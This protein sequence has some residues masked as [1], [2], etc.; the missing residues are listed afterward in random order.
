MDFKLMLP[1][2]RKGFHVWTTNNFWQM[3]HCPFSITHWMNFISS[4]LQNKKSSLSS[5]HELESS[6]PISCWWLWLP[7]DDLGLHQP[8]KQF[9]HFLMPSTM[10]S[11]GNFTILSLDALTWAWKESLWLVSFLK[12][13][14]QEEIRVFHHILRWRQILV[15]CIV[16][17][18]LQLHY[19]SLKNRLTG[20]GKIWTVLEKW[21]NT[22]WVWTRSGKHFERTLSLSLT[23]PS[24]PLGHPSFST[25]II[26]SY[27]WIFFTIVSWISDNCVFS[28]S[29]FSAHLIW[30]VSG[31]FNKQVVYRLKYF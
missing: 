7:D 8:T 24:L 29:H 15:V 22:C 17:L 21:T 10:A 30:I 27:Q 16:R 25:I 13:L 23:N 19:S 1:P 18:L 6:S 14:L 5:L 4:K 11:R 3:Y 28:F 9:F 31:L 2:E 26:D 20:K 12:K